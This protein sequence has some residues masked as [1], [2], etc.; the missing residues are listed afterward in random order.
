LIP[1]FLVEILLRMGIRYTILYL[2]GILVL[3]KKVKVNYTR[4]I[5]S[6]TLLF[7]PFV[8]NIVF[9]SN[10]SSDIG[11]TANEVNHILTQAIPLSEFPFT[12]VLLRP[13]LEIMPEL[14]LFTLFIKPIRKR[15][16]VVRTAFSGLN[17]PE[18]E[19]YTL[20]WLVSQ[21]SAIY[22][23]ASIVVLYLGWMGRPELIFVIIFISGFGDGLAE[24]IG[25]RFGKHKYEVKGF[26]VN[27]KFV[28]SL[29]GSA[30]VFLTS[31]ISVMLFRLS[32]SSTQF[33][34][35]LCAF[36]IVMTLT[37]AK[38]PHTWDNP[39][40]IAIGGILFFLIFQFLS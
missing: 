18:D 7:V 33:I 11:S 4:K 27:K 15:M 5:N 16:A 30:C 12:T 34:I 36:P 10:I 29:E 31:A 35:A 21:A 28:R 17:R 9:G 37:E 23:V 8:L 24:P 38:A 20:L 19:P 13:I 32:F 1:G 39:L 40:I 22:I 2:A 26:F 3:R 14:L 6:F 25:I